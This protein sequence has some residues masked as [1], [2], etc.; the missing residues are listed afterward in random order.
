[1]NL[2]ILF[3]LQGPKAYPISVSSHSGRKPSTRGVV[4]PTAQPANGT[5][6]LTAVLQALA[7]SVPHQPPPTP[8]HLLTIKILFL[9]IH[10]RLG[11]FYVLVV[12]GPY[13]RAQFFHDSIP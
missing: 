2:R 11:S 12:G 10:T 8:L 1:M 9:C 6:P 3:F 4:A 13:A 7:P 5:H